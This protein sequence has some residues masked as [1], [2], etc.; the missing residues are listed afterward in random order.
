MIVN[1]LN[2]EDNEEIA[3]YE[4]LQSRLPKKK[5]ALPRDCAST[6]LVE[7]ACSRANEFGTVR[8]LRGGGRGSGALGKTHKSFRVAASA[9]LSG[10]RHG[11][12]RN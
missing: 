9:R 3:I 8:D 7:I 11:C 12:R 5:R 10:V 6:S 2:D 1:S 4:D